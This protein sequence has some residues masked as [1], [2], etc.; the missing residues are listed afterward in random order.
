MK[1][2]KN[3][4]LSLVM[5]LCLFILAACGETKTQLDYQVKVNTNTSGYTVETITNK[6]EIE[7]FT[8][9]S[10]DSYIGNNTTGFKLTMKMLFDFGTDAYMSFDATGI[11]LL[12]SENPQ[13]GIKLNMETKAD[14]LSFK[15][16]SSM[17]LKNNIYYIQIPTG[18]YYMN[19]EDSKF[20]EYAASFSDM[21]DFDLSEEFT[22]INEL[23]NEE[24]VKMSKYVKVEKNK[25][26]T[27]LK[28][29]VPN[30]E[31]GHENLVYL[32]FENDIFK[33][34]HYSLDVLGQ[35]VKVDLVP[36]NGKI[37]FPSFKEYKNIASIGY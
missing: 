24:S 22:K 29:N 10:G 35:V 20:E 17:Y 3:L 36:F 11:Y 28:I 4:A 30:P 2:F 32:V 15:T 23:L 5:F 13:L 14:S 8:T 1:K 34:M 37:D 18:K 6:D 9:E 33:G 21:K 31:G 16:T 25:T 19:P 12:A 7:K 27:K 26:T